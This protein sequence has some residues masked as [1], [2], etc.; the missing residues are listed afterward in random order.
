MDEVGE[1]AVQS[2]LLRGVPRLPRHAAR[3]PAPQRGRD[4]ATGT[5]PREVTPRSPQQQ[6]GSER[7]WPLQAK[8]SGPAT[9]HAHGSKIHRSEDPTMRRQQMSVAHR[10]LSGRGVGG[11]LDEGWGLSCVGLFAAVVHWRVVSPVQEPLGHTASDRRPN[12][13]WPVT[14]I[15][16][17]LPNNA[18]MWSVE[19]VWEVTFSSSALGV[20]SGALRQ[21]HRK[22]HVSHEEQEWIC[23]SGPQSS[24]MLGNAYLPASQQ[25]DLDT[26]QRAHDAA[27]SGKDDARRSRVD[28]CL[29]E[30]RAASM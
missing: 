9:S 13:R 6:A 27:H 1:A 28:K 15:G 4:R 23:M 16:R 20:E 11:C 30:S 19:C 8:R 26:S 3:S 29:G 25:A 10:G 21:R 18:V 17:V 7:A 24:M 14:S 2:G 5:T 12:W 22:L